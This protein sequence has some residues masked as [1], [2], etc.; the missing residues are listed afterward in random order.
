MGIMQSCGALQSTTSCGHTLFGKGRSYLRLSLKNEQP[1]DG[2]N[3]HKLVLVSEWRLKL[4]RH[5][6][7]PLRSSGVVRFNTE[8]LA[9]VSTI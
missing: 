7:P 5:A 3:G 6:E 8:T 9:P 2:R 1:H 4:C